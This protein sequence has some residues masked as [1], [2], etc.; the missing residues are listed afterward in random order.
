M[1]SAM[2]RSTKLSEEQAALRQAWDNMEDR[3]Q[4]YRTE[5]D[6]ALPAPLHTL[7]QWLQRMEAILA[8][9]QGDSDDHAS[10]ARNARDKQEQLKALSADMSGHLDTLHLFHNTDDDGSSQIPV[11]KLDEL[12]RRFTSARVT[13]KYH[14]I[15]L[16]YWE[17]WHHVCELLSH[18]KSKLNSWKGPYGSQESVLSLL[19]DWDDTIKKQGLV[20]ILKTALHK[21]KDTAST[22]TGK[23]ALSEDSG[24]VNRQAKEAESEAAVSSEEADTL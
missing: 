21:L 10:A 19:Q 15:K 11:E 18:L 24:T 5:L 4:R 14:G 20:S 22:Y 16:E 3:L 17:H 1:M 7:A 13:A 23:A 6:V 12:K 8:E 2:R 9:E